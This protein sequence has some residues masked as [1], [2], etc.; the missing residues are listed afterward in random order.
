MNTNPSGY[1]DFISNGKKIEGRICT[2]S[3]SRFCLKNGGLTIS[4]LFELLTSGI[5]IQAIA[6]ILLCA[7]EYTHRGR[8]FHYTIDDA[9]DWIDGVGGL[10]NAV[11]LVEQAVVTSGE[12]DS[13]KKAT[14]R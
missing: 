1:F 8:E 11:K 14:R 9:L 3:L 4:Q 13:K 6:D 2:W 7:V 5:S 10:G 12:G